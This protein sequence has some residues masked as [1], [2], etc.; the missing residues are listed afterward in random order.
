MVKKKLDILQKLST[1]TAAMGNIIDS[2]TGNSTTD[3]PSIRAVNE[4]I[5]D[6]NTEIED[7]KNTFVNDN[8][9]TNSDFRSGIIN[10]KGQAS[11]VGSS[12]KVYAI[13]MW[14]CINNITKCDVLE[15]KIKIYNE[16]STDVSYFGQQNKQKTD[17]Y[18]TVAIF[19]SSLSGTIEARLGYYSNSSFKEKKYTLKN[20]LNVFT[21]DE[22]T[23]EFMQLNFV[24]SPNSSAYLE[25]A[26][27]EKGKY[28]TGMPLWN[29]ALE[30]LKCYYR[31]VDF[32]KYAIKRFM[33]VGS[34]MA[35]ITFELPNSM[36]KTPSLVFPAGVKASWQ[37]QDG[38]IIDTT[39]DS[40]SI[41]AIN[42]NAV[43]V[44][45]NG[46]FGETSWKVA[47]CHSLGIAFD[48][49]DY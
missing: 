9:L 19:I 14:A 45:L 34:K 23:D 5:G 39:V 36:V 35:Y 8:L 13:D 21:T 38:N 43:S 22:K 25:Y 44:Q 2:L 11:Y 15:N 49:Y 10:Q 41:L 47:T 12:S 40:A 7:V 3:A 1:V 33:F 42:K 27:V 48:A 28:F 46:N 16:D 31:Y 24:N 30:V 20:G 6:I 29:R 32:N 18:L 17:D 4:A 26:K 37:K